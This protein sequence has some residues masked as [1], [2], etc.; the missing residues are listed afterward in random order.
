MPAAANTCFT[1]N[2]RLRPS[3]HLGLL[4]PCR[5][6]RLAPAEERVEECLPCTRWPSS[7]KRRRF[8][9]SEKRTRITFTLAGCA[10]TMPIRACR[11]PA[12]IS[13]WLKSLSVGC[14]SA[15]AAQQPAKRHCTGELRGCR[16]GNFPREEANARTSLFRDSMALRATTGRSW[17]ARSPENAQTELR[18]REG[19]TSGHL[20]CSTPHAVPA[21]TP[22]MDRAC[23]GSIEKHALNAGQSY[24]TQ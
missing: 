9:R 13:S 14:G 22:P 10:L 15:Q 18:N 16:S 24:P 7:V 5:P 1:R 19:L 6:S 21:N 23:P 20:V 4:L 12:S 2:P 11:F 3:H 8:S 17:S